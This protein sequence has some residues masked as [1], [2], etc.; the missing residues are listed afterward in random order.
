[1]IATLILPLLAQAAADKPPVP[2]WNCDDPQVQ[3]EMNWCASRDFAVA[4]E[5]LNTQWKITSEVMKQRDKEWVKIGSADTRPG[6]FPQ[7]ARSPARLAAVSRCALSG[8]WLH[9]ARRHA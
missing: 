4:D 5:R 9:R 3:Q 6:F 1:M 7:P 2:E 8:G